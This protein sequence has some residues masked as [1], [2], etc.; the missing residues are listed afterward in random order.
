MPTTG[1]G[2][3]SLTPQSSTTFG[4]RRVAPWDTEQASPYISEGLAAYPDLL[5]RF[6]VAKIR[7]AIYQVIQSGPTF[8]RPAPDDSAVKAHAIFKEKLHWRDPLK[9]LLEP[10]AKD[11]ADE[12]AIGGLRNTA[13]SVGR[14]SFTAAHGAKLGNIL[15][16]ALDKHPDWIDQTC[17]AIGSNDDERKAA[18]QPPLRPHR[19][20]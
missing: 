10:T 13:E 4:I 15:K 3:H 17:D 1:R 8:A 7:K 14:L 18:G 5:N 12:A 2:S 11:K 19:K 9:G 6:I 20:Q 16:D